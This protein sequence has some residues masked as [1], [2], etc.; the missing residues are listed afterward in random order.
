MS[1]TFIDLTKVNWKSPIPLAANLPTVGNQD[2]D[3]IVSL[4]NHNINVWNAAGSAWVVI[5]TG[6]GG[7]SGTVTSVGVNTDSSTTA[8]FANSTNK[9]TGSPVTTAGN[10]TLTLNSQTTN[11]FLGSPN[12]STG[13]PTFRAL[14]GADLPNPGASSLGGTQSAAAVS[15]QWINSIS[16]SGVPA[17][18]QPA[19][20]DISGTATVAQGGTGASSLAGHGAVVMNS[21]G[22][23]QTIVAPGTSGNVLTSDGTNWTSAAGGGGGG[24]TALTGDVTAS[25]TGSVAATVVSAGGGTGAFSSG[26]ITLANTDAVIFGNGGK[27]VN[28]SSGETDFVGSG[29]N[30]MFRMLNDKGITLDNDL[31]NTQGTPNSYIGGTQAFNHAQP[32]LGMFA[33]SFIAGATNSTALYSVA[34]TFLGTE[35]STPGTLPPSGFNAL[36]FKSDHNLYQ[37]TSGGTEVRV[38]QGAFPLLGPVATSTIPYSFV[39]SATSGMRLAT[40]ALDGYDGPSF[41][42]NNNFFLGVNRAASQVIV[43]SG[44]S[45]NA[46]NFSAN[47]GTIGVLTTSTGSGAKIQLWGSALPNFGINTDSNATAGLLQFGMYNGSTLIQAFSW[48]SATRTTLTGSVSGTALCDQPQSGTLVKEVQIY[49]NN[50]GNVGAQSFTFPVAFINAPYIYGLTG[51]VAIASASTTALT[52]TGGTTL[53]GWVFAKGY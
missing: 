31:Y 43:G 17:L 20:T 39:G 8:I 35:I 21:G 11:K 53:T 44:F 16:T 32:H 30:I 4:D 19:F 23:A 5:G 12:G 25:G 34:G 51:G 27:F 7:G 45:L 10:M 33:N 9:I 13:V 3:A 22:T 18:S 1:G 38:T 15:H 24:I 52:L 28:A 41:Y 6:G 14:A 40:I 36:Y 48:Q 26:T 50:Y 49:L 46:N 37:V 29:G 2:G 47:A 42:D